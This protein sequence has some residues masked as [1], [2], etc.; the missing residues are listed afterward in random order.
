MP[1]VSGTLPDV[2]FPVANF[3]LYPFTIIN[4]VCVFSCSVVSSSAILWAVVRQ[5]PLS[6]DFS[7]KKTGVGS[8]FLCQQIFPTHGSN[9]CLLCFLH[10]RWILYFLSHQGSPVINLNHEHNSFAKFCS[11]L[12]N[13]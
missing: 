1:V 2:P 9:L 7:G 13:Y 8:H 3:N 12:A 10:C 11:L 4:H 5:A 6:M